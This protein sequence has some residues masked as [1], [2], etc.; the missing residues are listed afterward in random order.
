MEGALLDLLERHTSLALAAS[1]A[2]GTLTMMTPALERLLGQAYAP[3]RECDL[4][5]Q[6]NLYYE[7]GRTP[8]QTIDMPIARARAGEQVIDAIVTARPDVESERLTYLRCN[9]TPLRDASTEICGALVLVQDVT[10]EWRVRAREGELRERL[11]ATVNHELRTPVAKLLGHAELLLDVRDQMPGWARASLDT[12]WRASE[13]LADLSDTITS[14]VDLEAAAHIVPTYCDV[15]PVLHQVADDLTAKFGRRCGATIDVSSPA[16]LRATVDL[17]A[18][19]RAVSELVTNAMTY[20]PAASQ[21]AIEGHVDGSCLVITVADDGAG[22]AEDDY[23]RLLRP[24]ERGAH[25]GQPV[26]S[27]GLGLAYARAIATAH[28]GGLDL[29]PNRPT[30]LIAEWRANGLGQ[31]HPSTT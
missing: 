13:E 29:R 11:M 28:A 21:I 20:A 4:S 19:T 3:V 6:M 24:F 30:G 17:R 22:I 9:A 16:H 25:D 15:A 10:E 5:A 23:A 2:D 31:R 1:D 8:L 12:V 7:D 18:V 27:R 26:S 14:L